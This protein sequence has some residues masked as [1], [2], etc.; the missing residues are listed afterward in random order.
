MESTSSWP[1]FGSFDSTSELWGDY[2][3]RFITFCKAH[4]FPDLRRPSVFLMNQ[5]SAIYK[6]LANLVAKQTLAMDINYLNLKK[7]EEHMEEQFHPIRFFA[8]ERYK[9]WLQIDCKPAETALQLAA[10]IQQDAVT[11]D[12]RSPG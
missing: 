3:S 1:T 5:S 10:R 9:F 4:S 6:M 11:R 8:R 2:W 12:S 7:M